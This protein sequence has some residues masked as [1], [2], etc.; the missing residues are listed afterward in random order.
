MGIELTSTEKVKKIG[1][2]Y[3]INIRKDLRKRLELDEDDLVEIKIKK[4]SFKNE[5]SQDNK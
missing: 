3:Y 2:S 5:D 4:N 1:N